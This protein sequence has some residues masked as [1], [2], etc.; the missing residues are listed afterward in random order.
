MAYAARMVPARNACGV[1]PRRRLA[2]GGM[3]R[4]TLSASTSMIVSADG[5]ATSTA[6]Y[7]SRAAK[8]SLM[9]RAPTRGRTASWKSTLASSP[10]TT[11]RA[12]LVVPLRVEVPRGHHHHDLVDV[13]VR[14]ERLQGVLEDRVARDLEQLLGDVE[15]DP[16]ADP[17]RQ[18]DGDVGAARRGT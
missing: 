18:D 7:R 3:S 17:A 8:H 5:I 15:P 16:G 6:S 13:R 4:I 9:I 1:C 11:S 14:V 10:P 2:R 12:P